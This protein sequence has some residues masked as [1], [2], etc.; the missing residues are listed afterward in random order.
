MPNSLEKQHRPPEITQSVINDGKMAT[1]N[2]EKDNE[3][4]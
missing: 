2:N 4:L 1:T 3:L